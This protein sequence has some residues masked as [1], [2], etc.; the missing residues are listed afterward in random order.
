MFN[1][2][3]EDIRSVRQR[4]PAAR[5]G[6]EILLVYAGVHALF[7]HRPAH[8]L[9]RHRCFLLARLISQLTRFFTG[10]EI[11]PGAVIGHNVFIDHGSGT[12]IG[13]TAEVGDGCTLYQGVTL[14]G[15]GKDTG[16]RHP[17][18]GRNV[19]VGCGAKVL[20]P[21]RVGDNCKI[22]ANAVLL[23]SIDADSTA[24]GVPAR[25]V[26]V[27]GKP[28]YYA[29][30]VDQIHVADPVVEEMMHMSQRIEE[31]EKELHELKELNTKKERTA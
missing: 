11:H 28:I 2:I 30:D 18:L 1:R 8:W 25:V 31:L 22:A 16:K 19:M 21:V 14:G 17:T 15:T 6:F 27:N 9:Y 29:D 13:E 7:W 20:G 3:R 4:D 26:R 23:H 5:S 24:V 10:I 12:V